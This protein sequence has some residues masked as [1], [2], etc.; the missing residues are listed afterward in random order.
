M[1]NED[2]IREEFNRQSEKF[3]RI[4]F[5]LT[6]AELTAWMVRS[7]ELSPS[8]RVLDVAAGTGLLT[9]AIAPN[10]NP[11]NA[12]LKKEIPRAVTH[13]PI[14]PP[15]LHSIDAIGNPFSSRP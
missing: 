15:S 14:R 4:G 13:P 3:D 11:N 10:V 12:T 8:M 7:L 1:G 9:C 5:T 6:D 2:L